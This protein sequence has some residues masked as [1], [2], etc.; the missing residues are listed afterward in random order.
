MQIYM[1]DRATAGSGEAG[2]TG[3]VNKKK[4]LISSND[5][6]LLTTKRVELKY[7]HNQMKWLGTC[8][9]WRTVAPNRNQLS[10]K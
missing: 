1:G 4:H 9:L 5:E 2:T 6:A 7:L 10:T 8:T 3:N